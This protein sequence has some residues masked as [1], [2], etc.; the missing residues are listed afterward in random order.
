[1]VGIGP[2][3]HSHLEGQRWWNARSNARYLKAAAT[4]NW[5]G[6]RDS[7]SLSDTDRFNEGLIT[8]LRRIEGVDP[9]RLLDQ[10][11]LDL[12]TQPELTRLLAEGQCEWAD[13]RLRIP[14]ARWPMGDAITLE[15]IA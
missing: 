15:L 10:T 1:M 8:G 12:R 13:G 5:S 2:G 9:S 4:G 11:G 6:Q 3:A 7:E 14:E